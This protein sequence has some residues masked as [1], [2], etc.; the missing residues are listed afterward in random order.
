M[1]CINRN[2]I[3]PPF[4]TYGYLNLVKDFRNL[5]TQ[6]AYHTRAY[7][8]A[9][10]SGFGNE[11]AIAKRLYDL[12]NKFKEKAE[13]IF[14]TPLSEEF[15]TLLSLHVTY[16]EAIVNAIKNGDQATVD[17][18]TQQLYKN[19]N[20]IAA[21]YARMNPFWDETQWKVLLYNYVGMIIQ[22]AVALGSREFEKD[23]DIFDRMLLAALAMG[24][25][26]AEGFI[27]YLT[28][29]RRDTV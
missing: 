19:A 18:Y 6:L 7:M 12:P 1:I 29:T 20:D 8:V 27:Q 11:E 3:Q 5:M 15:L 4:I 24:D 16:I 28:A 9:V 26:Q 23:L 21:H 22:D 14:G 2:E 25:Y 17:Y 13:L 10:Y